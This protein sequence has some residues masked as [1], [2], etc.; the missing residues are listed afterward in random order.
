[1]NSGLKLRE[2]I[3]IA[4]DECSVID[5]LIS[6]NV[7]ASIVQCYKCKRDMKLHLCEKMYRCMRRGCRTSRS[8]FKGTFFENVKTGIHECFDFCYLYLN[9]VGQKSIK[10]LLGWSTATVSAWTKYITE[11]LSTTLEESSM[12]IGGDNIE[13]E[14]DETKMGKRKYHRG[15]RVDGVWVVAGVERTEEKKIFA[16][17]VENRDESTL[18]DIINKHVLPGSI[19]LTDGWRAYNNACLEG[20]FVHKVVNHSKYFKDPH[21]GVHTNTIEGFNNGFKTFVKPRNRTRKSVQRQLL[22]YIWFKQHKENH[23]N[24]FMDGLKQIY[25]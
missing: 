10:K 1:M 23:W 16:V 17:M 8:I 4:K 20:G 21:T 7:I 5:Y 9:K 2:Y 13:V 11:L 22:C 14:I 6:N 12:K 3:E 19:I 15:H 24:A 18:K 25:Y